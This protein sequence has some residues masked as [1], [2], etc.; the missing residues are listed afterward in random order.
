MSEQAKL[1]YLQEK[2]KEAKGRERSG[3][4]AFIAG[5]IV[6]SIGFALGE[7]LGEGWTLMGIGGILAAVIG[8][9]ESF[10]YGYQHS[11]LLEQLKKMAEAL[12]ACPKCG[13]E[14][15]QGNYAFCPFCGTPLKARE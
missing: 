8:I 5:V 14:I 3:M 6:A 11:K 10:Y 7:V 1:I 9:V 2:I 12:P 15:P 4:I 13:K